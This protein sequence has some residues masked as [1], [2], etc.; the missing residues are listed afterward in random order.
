M[1]KPIQDLSILCP[2]CGHHIHLQIDCSEEID[3]NYYDECPAC[4]RDIHINL[5]QDR[6]EQQ[7]DIAVDAD[8]EQIF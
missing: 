4:C 3:Q 2:H 8:D 6:I 7:L 1:T 5:H